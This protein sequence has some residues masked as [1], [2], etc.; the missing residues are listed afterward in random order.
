MFDLHSK[1]IFADAKVSSL[2][3]VVTSLYPANLRFSHL[4]INLFVAIVYLSF[5]KTRKPREVCAVCSFHYIHLYTCNSNPA[6]T[7]DYGKMFEFYA[8]SDNDVVFSL[9]KNFKDIN[10]FFIPKAKFLGYFPP[11]CTVYN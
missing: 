6:K 3:R 2:A 7:A 5:F 10:I 4:P 8:I 1:K 11:K 9:L